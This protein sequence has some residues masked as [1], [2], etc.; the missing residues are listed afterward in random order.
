MTLPHPE[1]DRGATDLAAG[2]QPSSPCAEEEL[3][4]DDDRD[5]FARLG[6]ALER[7]TT[8]HGITAAA[9]QLVADGGMSL[10]LTE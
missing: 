10:D 4:S 6:H 3:D 2:E 1:S 7:I 5:G 9:A 8:H